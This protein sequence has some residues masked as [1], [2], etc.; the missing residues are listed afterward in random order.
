[1]MKTAW[2]A[3]AMAACTGGGGGSTVDGGG[4]TTGSITWKAD[5]A[6]HS[7][8][9][10]T[11]L[12]VMATGVGI[13]AGDRTGAIGLAFA[14][15]TAGT[16]TIGD[17][18]LTGIEFDDVVA[19]TDWKAQGAIGSGMIVITTFDPHELVGTFE[20][21]LPGEHGVTGSKAITEGQFD[22]TY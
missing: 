16:Y 3:L 7:G 8:S 10:V 12:T 9:I 6:Q 5:G 18:S 20:G 11:D 15:T 21:D 14:G 17:T 1:M 2:F 4:S 19:K 13:A 22:L